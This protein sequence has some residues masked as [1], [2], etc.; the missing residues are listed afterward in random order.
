[1]TETDLE[2]YWKFMAD[3][4][5]RDMANA[6][7]YDK[8]ILTLS[9]V[10]LGLSLTFIQEVI[11]LDRASYLPMLHGAW[12]VLVVTIVWVITAFIYG[13]WGARKLKEFAVRYFLEGDKSEPEK[14]STSHALAILWLNTLAGVLFIAGII[15]L[16]AFVSI[17]MPWSSAG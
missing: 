15:L 4:S 7:A 2:L 12:A 13:Q 17:N 6:E 10:F 14:F 3:Q 8:A 11:P 5:Q 1:M 9:S 16:T